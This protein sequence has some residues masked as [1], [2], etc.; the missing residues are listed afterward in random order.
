M[1]ACREKTANPSMELYVYIFKAHIHFTVQTVI[2][3]ERPHNLKSLNIM[4]MVVHAFNPSTREAE[5][6]GFLS[7]RPA[8]STK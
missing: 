4:G 2:T 8:W 6:E 7:S 5:A 1:Q 3:F